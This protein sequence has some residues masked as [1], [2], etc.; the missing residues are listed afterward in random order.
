MFLPDMNAILAGPVASS[1]LLPSKSEITFRKIVLSDAD[2][3]V[4]VNYAIQLRTG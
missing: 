1:L 2:Y 4:D 3:S